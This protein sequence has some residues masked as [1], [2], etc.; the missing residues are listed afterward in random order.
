MKVSW[1]F[2]VVFC[3]LG[4]PRISTSLKRA[5]LVTLVVC[6]DFPLIQKQET[7]SSH[8]LIRA[9]CRIADR[10]L[11]EML[12]FPMQQ[13]SQTANGPEAFAWRSKGNSDDP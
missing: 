3:V 2:S 8:G 7:V 12:A 9:N 13:C 5:F 11:K 4:L 10:F 6:T 1:F